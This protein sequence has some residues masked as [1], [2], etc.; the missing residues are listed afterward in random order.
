MESPQPQQHEGGNYH[1]KRKRVVFRY[2]A[3]ENYI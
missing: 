2:G 3:Q 1:L